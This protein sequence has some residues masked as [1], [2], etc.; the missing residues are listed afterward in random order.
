MDNTTIIKKYLNAMFKKNQINYK[1]AFETTL[2]PKTKN[3]PK[4]KRRTFPYRVEEPDPWPV[5]PFE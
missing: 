4:T 5:D 3:T 2:P 1:F